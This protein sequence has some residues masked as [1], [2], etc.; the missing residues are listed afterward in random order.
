GGAL[1]RHRGPLLLPRHHLDR[2]LG[3]EGE[4]GS[5][6][7]VRQV[8]ADSQDHHQRRSPVAPGAIP[9]GTEHATRPRRNAIVLRGLAGDYRPDTWC[10]PSQARSPS[11]TRLTSCTPPPAGRH[12]GPAGCC[13]AS[14]ASSRSRFCSF[15]GSTMCRMRAA[16]AASSNTP[17]QVI[18][19]PPSRGASSTVST[20]RGA[21]TWWITSRE[22]AASSRKAIAGALLA[23]DTLPA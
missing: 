13:S 22:G 23:R 1:C 4:R 7:R 14:R 20:R 18:V 19:V 5:D 9:H 2:A 11:A 12:A 10:G 16:T 15:A 3:I 6:E 8:Q 17:V 21:D